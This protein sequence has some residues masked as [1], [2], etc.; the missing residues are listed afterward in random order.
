M[1]ILTATLAA[2][3]LSAAA[4]A[5]TPTPLHSVRVVTPA[6]RPIWIGQAPGDST[7]L[8]V[9]EQKQHDVEVWINGVQNALPFLDLTGKVA[10][11]GNEQGLLG[12]AFHPDFQNNGWV[13]VNYTRSGDTATIVERY[14]ALTADDADETSGVTVFG[15]I[16]QPQSNHNGGNIVFGPDGKLYVGMGDGGNANDT[17]P[18]HVAGGN[19]QAPG[20]ALGKMH[21][22]NDD[23][24][25]PGD[26][27]FI[28]NGAFVQ[29]IWS[30]GLRNPWRWSF[31]AETGDLWI[32][33]VGQDA[34][35]EV[36]FEPAGAGG[37][38]Y[39]WRCMEGFNCTGLSGCTCND[40]A[41]T[42]PI[43]DYGHSGGKC[44]VTGGYLYR[45]KALPD[46]VGTYFFAD[47]CT[48]QIFSMDYN[49]VTAVVTDRTAEV[50]PGGGLAIA[51]ITSFGVDN[52]GELYMCEQGAGGANGEV[53]KLVPEGP[54][55]GLGS[56]LAGIDGKPVLWGE[57]TL[58]TG[59]A[60][61]LNLRDVAPSATGLLFVALSEGSAAFKGGVVV[62]VPS[63][64]LIAVASDAGGELQLAW[65]AWPA[66]PQGTTIVFQAGFDDVA[67]IKGVS[68]TNGLRAVQP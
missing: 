19:G 18:G 55:T 51:L 58:V 40:V 34:R 66:L 61:A 33:D 43:H 64:S 3:L 23:G 68:L 7:R 56:A 62:A 59:S 57:G 24:S 65:P 32:A 35:E 4:L 10:S 41:L 5:Q 28:G 46:W 25:I 38:N 54:F 9:A 11:G 48:A 15:P 60:G 42:L 47:Y 1:K 14:T 26:N 49:G 36:D 30:L 22:I 37:R 21:R 6:A 2:G 31:D 13:Y 44:S 27:P 45:G 12:V 20:E 52:D 50:A 53:F 39:G 67:A 29:S 8:Y 17:G 63:V 16:A